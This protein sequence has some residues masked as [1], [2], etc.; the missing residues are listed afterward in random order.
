[1]KGRIFL[2]G[3]GLLLWLGIIAWSCSDKDRAEES[4]SAADLVVERIK[5]V[6]AEYVGTEKCQSCHE[7]EY[8]EWKNSDHDWA[9]QIAMDTTVLGDFND[10]KVTLNGITSHFFKRDGKY[11]INTEGKDGNYHDF[12]VKYTFGYYPLQ[13]YMTENEDGRIQ[14]HRVTWDSEKNRWFNQHDELDMHHGEWLNWTGAAGTWNTMCADCHS[15]DLK[16]NYDPESDTFNTTFREIN[17]GCE[18]CHGEGSHHVEWVESED[19]DEDKNMEVKSFM[20]MTAYLDNKQLVRECAP[21]HSRRMNI[22]IDNQFE[23]EFMDH[24]VPEIL[25][26]GMYHGDGSIQDEVYVYGSFVQSKMYE[27]G[28]KCTDCH[29]PHTSRIKGAK[30]HDKGQWV[31]D[32]TVCTN[33]HLKG[34]EAEIYDTPKHHFHEQ[35]TEAS[36]CI[37]CHFVGEYYMG[38]DYRP[39]HAFRVPRPDQSVEYGIKNAC[40]RCHEDQSAQWAADAVV[41]WYGPDRDINYTD[42][43]LKG[44]E[45]DP[46]NVKEIA[47]FVRDVSQPEIARATAVHYLSQTNDPSVVNPIVLALND[48]EPLVRYR[49]VEA[50]STWSDEERVTYLVPRLKDEIKSVRVAAVRTLVGPIAQQ[51]PAEYKGAYEQAM[52]EYM[53]SLAINAD[54]RNGNFSYGQYYERMGDD[55]AAEKY[56]IRTIGMDSLFNAARVQLANLYNRKGENDK[57][58]ERLEEVIEIEPAYGGAYYSI[59][60]IKAEEQDFTAAEKYLGLGVEKGNDHP[61]AYY[62]WALAAQ[63]NKDLK[64]AEKVYKMG[65]DRYGNALDLRN[66][67]AIM[68]IQNQ[69]FKE[70]LAQID[71]MDKIS[72]NNPQIQQMKQQVMQMM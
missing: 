61:R 15:T 65:I 7:E 54:F 57:A 38:N 41:E 37:S 59:G 46:A 18:A 64:K 48:P 8:G 60:L 56:Y 23:G 30:S 17:V 35:D 19:Y 26:D 67:Y 63:Q 71:A 45:R 47:K 16:K 29:N 58:L 52:T 51:V 13:N 6:E 49:A 66:A 50:I 44:R 14:V 55:L 40:N 53:K 11:F 10:T 12:E 5:S 69:R 42:A 2:L 22:E 43:L 33:C 20:R 3:G 27:H 4:K 36:Q 9:M 21:C 39:D 72:P 68:L 32:N 24:F 25:R 28:V 62:N 31:Y 1:M 70:A 34:H